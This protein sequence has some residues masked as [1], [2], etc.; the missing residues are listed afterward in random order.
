MFRANDEQVSI[1]DKLTR[2]KFQTRVFHCLLNEISFVI[3]LRFSLQPL[4]FY[5]RPHEILIPIFHLSYE[6]AIASTFFFFS[7]QI[8][9]SRSTTVLEFFYTVKYAREKRFYKPRVKRYF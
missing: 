6:F 3:A 2:E 9:T 5:Y 7:I 8:P 1:N 4:L